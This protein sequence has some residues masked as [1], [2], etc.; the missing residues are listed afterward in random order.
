MRILFTKL[1]HI[2]DNLLITPIM[3]A[4]KRKYP[5][6]EIWLAV[7]RS[8]EGILAGCPEIDRI[9]TTARPEESMRSWR[10]RVE[11]L[12]TLARIARTHFDYA[13]ELGD[14]DR[15]RLLVAASMAP[16][17]G[18]H[19]GEPGLNAF[20]QRAFTDIVPTDRS[21]MHQV[22]MDYIIPKRVLGLP[23]EPPPMRFDAAAT[24]PWKGLFD[25]EREDFAVLHAATRWESKSWPMERWREVLGRILEF[26][27]RVIV[28]CG[29]GAEEVAG[30][31]FLCAGFG[32]RVITTGGTAS[33]NQLAWL[34]ARAR[35]YIGVDTAAMHL[36]AA[37]QCP[38]VTLFGQT[39]P[40]QFGPWKSPHVMVAPA[41]RS[42]GEP[43]EDPGKLPNHRLLEISSDAV[44]AA[45]R[46]ASGMRRE[47]FHS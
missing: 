16:F 35:Y 31:G 15:G 2:G 32:D 22:E 3:V 25:P 1:R 45:C 29:P 44:V 6:A 24:R 12:R 13:F 27:P 14:N 11:D 8:T 46:Q 5:E 19:R 20:W 36:A 34:L 47:D 41:G 21:A 23:E 9:V 43:S 33:W 28:S 40:G 26:T 17:R 42:V 10:N 37:M 38:A 30:A 18:A 7:R 4:T 39:I